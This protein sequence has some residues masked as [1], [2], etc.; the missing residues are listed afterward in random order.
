M[1]HSDQEILTMESS[2]I[3]RL[4]PDRVRQL[5]DR[6]DLAARRTAEG[7]RLF[8]R[9]DVERLAAAREALKSAR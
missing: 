1:S 8:K 7:V 2:R 9:C 5:A 6:G 4:S 3:L